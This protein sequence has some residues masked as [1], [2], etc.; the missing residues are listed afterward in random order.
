LRSA[1]LSGETPCA[2]VSRATLP[3]QRTV[4]TSVDQ[5]HLLPKLAAPTLLVV[6]QVVQFAAIDGEVS[7]SPEMI[8]ALHIDS[9][10]EEPV[11]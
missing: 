5:L 2:I 1:G 3:D 6:G 9:I 11:A 8:S 7:I 4:I 10:P